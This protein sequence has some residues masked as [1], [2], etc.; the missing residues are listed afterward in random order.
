MKGGRMEDWLVEKGGR[1][2][3]V[4][5]RNG[6]NYWEWQGIVAFCTCQWNELN[7]PF[8]VAKRQMGINERNPMPL[9]FKALLHGQK[10][11]VFF[12]RAFNL[13]TKTRAL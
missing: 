12:Q 8:G 9:V 3:Y 5:E 4:T 6:R 10:D 7:E 1:K 2:V 13:H 11:R